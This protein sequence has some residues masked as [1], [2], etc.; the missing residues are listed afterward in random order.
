MTRND[1]ELAFK[2]IFGMCALHWWSK[3]AEF[4]IDRISIAK[5][6]QLRALDVV[7]DVTFS[8]KPVC[9]VPRAPSFWVEILFSVEIS[10]T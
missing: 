8:V 10:E 9:L 1:F 4:T 5:L 6:D 2:E 7:K 3:G